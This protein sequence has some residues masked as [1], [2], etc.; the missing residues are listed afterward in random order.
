MPPADLMAAVLG[1]KIIEHIKTKRPE[2][3]Q[4]KN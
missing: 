3:R 2:P 1:V 4:M